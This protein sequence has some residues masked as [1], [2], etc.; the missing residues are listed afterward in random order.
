MKIDIGAHILPKGYKDALYK[1]TDTRINLQDVI[2]T[3]P[4]MYDLDHR[5]RVMDKFEGL[6]QVLTLS[7]PA[8]EE[9]S[10]AEKSP[11]FAKLAN[12]GM[13]ELVLKY[14]DRFVAAVAC[15]SSHLD[16]SH[17]NRGLFRLQNRKEIQID[18][19]PH[20]WLAL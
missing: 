4:T 16:P 18:D 19:F 8:V 6:M 10:D 5:F 1:L 9:F 17:E 15:Q 13:A 11:D 2:D 20:I 7:S 3:L 14:P 12:D